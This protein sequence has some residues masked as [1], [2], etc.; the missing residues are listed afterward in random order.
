MATCSN[1][2]L[3]EV[4][5]ADAV[6]MPRLIGADGVIIYE[7]HHLGGCHQVLY[8]S[9]FSVPASTERAIAPPLERR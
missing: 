5:P 9:T 1:G 6:M 2:C 8:P 7:S 4:D 3:R